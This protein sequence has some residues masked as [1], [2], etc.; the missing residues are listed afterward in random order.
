[1]VAQ[2]DQGRL[3]IRRESV[4]VEELASRVGARFERRAE[5]EGRRVLINVPEDL[6]ASLDAIRIEQAIGN[7]IDNALRH[8][9]GDIRVSAR[10]SEDELVIDVS[11]AGDGFPVG[12]EE[13]AFERFTRAEAGRTGEGAGLGLAIVEAIATAHGGHATVARAEPGAIVS[14]HVPS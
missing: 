8:G 12:F 14:I 1:V 7:L 2:S 4:R 11:D 3:P 5:E 10:P 9:A 13:Q 6:E